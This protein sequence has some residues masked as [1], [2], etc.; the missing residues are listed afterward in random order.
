MIPSHIT[1]TGIDAST[2]IRRLREIQRRYPLAEFGILASYDWYRRGNRFLE[3]RLIRRFLNDNLKLSLHL[4]GEAAVDFAKGDVYEINYLTWG[5]LNRFK[6]VQLNLAGNRSFTGTVASSPYIQEVIIQQSGNLALYERAYANRKGMKWLG[7]VSLLLDPSGGRGIDTNL[8]VFPHGG[9][10]GY[11]GGINPE[12]VR[13]KLAYL[14]DNVREGEFWIDMETGVRT[15]DLL[16]LDKVE[17]VLETCY[18]LINEK[19]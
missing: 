6:R 11:A 12:N 1:F 13:N 10:V 15:N 19:K 4:C 17:S 3:P 18:E 16:D 7:T 14:M 5:T 2:D 9:K 8:Q